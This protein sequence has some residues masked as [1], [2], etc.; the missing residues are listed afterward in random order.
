MKNI[1]ILKFAFPDRGWMGP[2]FRGLFSVP[3]LCEFN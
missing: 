3:L 2:G 1:E